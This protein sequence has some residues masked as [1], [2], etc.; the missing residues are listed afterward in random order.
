VEEVTGVSLEESFR[1]DLRLAVSW[2]T[3]RTGE[4]IY[5]EIMSV[6]SKRGDDLR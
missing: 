2:I 3:D 4:A 5:N 1:R 6:A